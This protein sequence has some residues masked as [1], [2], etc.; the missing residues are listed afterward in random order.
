MGLRN[1]KPFTF[2]PTGVTD[3][4]DG[5]NAPPGSLQIATNLIP[6]GDTKSAWVPRPGAVSATTFSGFSSPGFV[7]CMLVVG[8]I[9]YGLISTS[10]N[11]GKDEPFAYNILN[12]T[13]ETVTGITSANV[14]T[15]P[16]SS[17]A[18]VPPTMSLVGSCVMVTHP[19]FA[20]GSYK[21]GWFDISG[22]SYS[23][24]IGITNGSPTITS[25]TNLLQAGVQPGNVVAATGVPTGATILSINTAGTSAVISA[26]AT[27]T[28]AAAS[29][30][31]SGGTTTSPQWG[32]GDLNINP[33]VAVPVAVTQFNG[34]AYYAVGSSVVW[35]DSLLPRNRTLATQAQTFGN[36]LPVTAL[37]GLPLSSP[38]TGGIVQAVIAFQGVST[39]QQITGDQAT[40]NLAVN[41]MNVA[42]GTLAPLTVTPCNFGLAFVAPDGLRY[43]DFSG[44]ISNPVGEGGMGV[45]QPFVYAQYPSRMCAS[46]NADVIR[47]SVT[48]IESGTALNQ[49]WWFDITREVWSG[50]HSFPASLIQ[51]WVGTFLVAPLGVTGA[52]F[53][54]DVVPKTT[55]S[56]TENGAQMT[57]QWQTTL[58]PDNEAMCENA[59]METS[60][61]CG[62]PG[63][64][65]LT[66]SASDETDSPIATAAIRVSGS[67]TN[68]G[69]FT[70]GT[71]TW[72]G[73][74]SNLQQR[75]VPWPIPIVFKQMSLGL[76][77]QCLAGVE[78]GNHY[79]KR[80]ELGYLLQA[81]TS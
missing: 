64:Y 40:S 68:W 58:L 73:T 13:F 67:L 14:P 50:P 66:V 45:T 25:A 33:L 80:Q 43:V 47:I 57:F 34:R 36:G 21:I 27:A 11:S 41:Q 52:L 15:S 12:G 35:S 29:A 19:G 69:A 32:A 60:I 28:N 2:K 49:E 70:W 72:E 44:R 55:T 30:T 79:F 78:I 62:L 54:S 4:A 46:A 17:G 7:S 37:G 75:Q 1:A 20:G 9:C 8:N 56:Y 53:T 42:T 18:W 16:T 77:G 23:G 26:N 24:N 81:P 51:P 65:S 71:G 6:A 22:F 63:G 39:M 38:L 48:N 76:S 74:T 31:I 61:A 5:T 10:R 59:M 3:S